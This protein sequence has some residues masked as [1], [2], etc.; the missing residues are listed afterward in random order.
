MK[1]NCWR[2]KLE[3]GILEFKNWDIKKYVF[4]EDVTKIK[5]SDSSYKLIS[6]I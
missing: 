5:E 4:K 6:N 1:E 2:Q 3:S